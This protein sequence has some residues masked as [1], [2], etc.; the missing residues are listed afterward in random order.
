MTDSGHC[1]RWAV[2]Q[3]IAWIKH[4]TQAALGL[5]VWRRV[6]FTEEK[7][8]GISVGFLPDPQGS[9]NKLPAR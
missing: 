3:R 8:I 9:G 6:A 7:H 1:R 4:L 5:V 2:M